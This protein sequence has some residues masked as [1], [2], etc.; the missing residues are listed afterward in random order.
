MKGFSKEVFSDKKKLF[1]GSAFNKWHC[2]DSVN[3]LIKGNLSVYSVWWKSNAQGL[4]TGPNYPGNIS[5][6]LKAIL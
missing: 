3:Y 1:C 5:E 4:S 2:I 6:D